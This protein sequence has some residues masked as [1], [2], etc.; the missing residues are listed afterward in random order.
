MTWQPIETAP[1]DGTEIILGIP[2]KWGKMSLDKKDDRVGTGFYNAGAYWY[3]KKH[4]V[5]RNRVA[6]ITTSPTHWQPLPP[7]PK[8]ESGI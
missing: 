6:N 7:P 8:H 2:L 5:W 1:K 3:D 4:F